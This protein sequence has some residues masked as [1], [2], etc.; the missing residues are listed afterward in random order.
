METNNDEITSN[1]LVSATS[2]TGSEFSR[3]VVVDGLRVWT[4]SD[5]CLSSVPDHLLGATL[6]RTS[7]IAAALG[8]T[9]AITAAG[10]DCRLYVII[11]SSRDSGVPG[12]DG[13]LMRALAANPA[14]LAE[15][16]SSGLPHCGAS[17]ST[18]AAFS[19]FAVRDVTIVLPELTEEHTVMF[20]IAVPV[21]TG[22]FAVSL[23]SSSCPTY[24]NRMA[25]MREGITPWRNRD[26]KFVGVPKF[27]LGGILFQGPYKDIPDG[28]ILTVR[29]NARSAVYVVVERTASGGFAQNLPAAGWRQESGAPRWH[30]TPTMVVYRRNCSAGFLLTLPP[31]QGSNTVLSVVVVPLAGCPIAP[32]E[33]SKCCCSSAA[34]AK[35]LPEPVDPVPLIEGTPWDTEGTVLMKIPAWMAGAAYIQTAAS[36]GQAGPSSGFRFAIRAAPPSVVYVLIETRHSGGIGRNGQLLP[37]ALPAAGWEMRTETP[38]AGPS[39]QLAVYA[40][41]VAAGEPL[42]LPPIVQDG[43]VIGLVVKVDMEAFDAVAETN[44]GVELQKTEMRET[45]IAWIDRPFRYAWVPT[46]MVGGTLFRGPHLGF[47]T[48]TDITISASGACRVYVLVEAEYTGGAARDGG[49]LRSLPQAGWHSESFDPSWNDK[50]STVKVF[51]KRISDGEDITLPTVCDIAVFGVVVV[52]IAKT[53]DRLT[54]ETKLSFRSWDPEG[55]GGIKQ[56]D[57]NELLRIVCPSLDDYARTMLIADANPSGSGRIAYDEF[58]GKVL[59][60]GASS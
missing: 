39:I 33:V 23:T 37:D 30:D 24:G 49:F 42:C 43:A 29:P 47:P 27:L 12:R 60:A 56:D 2:S 28:T 41:R 52:N 18:M 11:E 21:V 54:E 8:S 5:E 7:K 17:D 59:L 13:G 15:S 48:G 58:I 6:L 20:L 16:G 57:L 1:F 25:I 19:V 14:W 51:S 34:A 35:P 50:N 44:A 3:L 53:P 32:V 26:H 4:D 46:A 31:T 9:T 40:K 22:N 36:F 45:V 55:L 38:D 10:S